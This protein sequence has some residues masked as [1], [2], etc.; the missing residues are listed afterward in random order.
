MT[1]LQQLM[2]GIDAD[3]TDV[4]AGLACAALLQDEAA[5]AARADPAACQQEGSGSAAAHGKEGASAAVAL[6][7]ASVAGVGEACSKADADGMAGSRAAG[8]AVDP[9]LLAWAEG[10]CGAAAAAKPEIAGTAA[11]AAAA[12]SIAEAAEALRWAR[13]AA[14]AY[15]ERQHFWRRGRQGWWA[16]RRQLRAGAAAAEAEGAAP[17]AGWPK[18]KPG[19]AE[20]RGFA[21]ARELLQPS[22]SEI[23]WLSPGHAPN[24]LLPHL[25]AVDRWAAGRRSCC[26]AVRG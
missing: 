16:A 5:Q 10:V 17:L 14:A 23:V 6:E 11:A 20:R 2:A 1:Q 19:A 22:G 12:A 8:G 4:V 9:E 21:A 24:G 26:G 15:G 3:K 25:V 18:G 7:A 13:C